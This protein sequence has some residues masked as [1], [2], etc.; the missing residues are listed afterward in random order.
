MRQ[1]TPPLEVSGVDQYRQARFVLRLH[2]GVIL[3]APLLT[4]LSG[5]VTRPA[6]WFVIGLFILFTAALQ[7]MISLR[8]SGTPWKAVGYAV[9]IADLF[10]VTSLVWARGGL[11]TDAYHFYYLVI[12][13]AAILF[14]GWQS[15]L[16][17]VAAGLLYG[18]VIWWDARALDVLGRVVIRTVYFALIGATAAYFSSEE[19]RH[20]LARDEA[21]RLLV[22]LQ[23]AHTQLKVH[24][25][26]MSQRAVTDG[27]T[28][29][30]NHTYFHQRIDEE[31]S[32]AERYHRPLALL[33]L[34]LDGFKTYNDTFGHPKGDLILAEVAR[35]I[36]SSVRKV[37]VVC[38]Y[39]G[40]EFAV[41]LPETGPG[42]ALAAAER[43]RQAVEGALLAAPLAAPDDEPLRAITVSAGVAGYPDNAANRVDLV[44]AADRALYLSKKKGKNTVTLSETALPAGPGTSEPG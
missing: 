19:R 29:L 18:L 9:M 23:E 36:T 37:D 38:R 40:E 25:R 6:G 7:A 21:R 28:G 33:M 3:L 10:L 8:P 20:R 26:E 43:I 41:I 27:L 2:W 1:A 11:A 5:K 39:G 31:L 17:A 14:G 4:V 16:F 15:F 12:V 30:Y 22:D 34:D 44:E 32:R 24:A 35:L 13:G 42:A